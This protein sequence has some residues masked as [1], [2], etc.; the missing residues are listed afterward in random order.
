MMK[1][2]SSNSKD[3]SY[4]HVLMCLI[5]RSLFDDYDHQPKFL[6]CHHTFC[7]DC[8]RE[9][10]RQIGD[11]IECPSCRKIANIPAAGVAALQTNFY[12][13]Y[14]QSLVSGGSGQSSYPLECAKH[15]SEKLQFF[16]ENCEVSMC[17]E[18]NTDSSATCD[19]EKK[20][21][22]TR[23]TEESH[24]K[25]DTSFSEANATIEERKVK[26]E[27]ALKALA[28]EKDSALLKID[29]TFEQ[30]V[31]TLNRRATLLKNKVIDIYN[32]HVERLE[33]DLMEISTA[34]TCIVSLKDYHEDKIS[35]GDYR[36]FSKGIE[37]IEEVNKNIGDRIHP[38]ETHII[39]EG[40]HGSEKFRA[41]AK[42]IGR[43]K[44][45]RVIQ[46]PRTEPEGNDAVDSGA[47]IA[48][49]TAASGAAPN[50]PLTPD[51]PTT[52]TLS[53]GLHDE[54]LTPAG[55]PDSPCDTTLNCPEGSG[56]CGHHGPGMADLNVNNNSNN[57]TDTVTTSTDNT[58]LENQAFAETQPKPQNC[59]VKKKPNL[60]NNNDPNTGNPPTEPTT[61]VSLLPSPD[62]SK[63]Q[64]V[65]NPG[66]GG[67]KEKN[68]H[69]QPVSKPPAPE[70]VRVVPGASSKKQA[71]SGIATIASSGGRGRP[72]YLTAIPGVKSPPAQP[73]SKSPLLAP[74]S[75]KSLKGQVQRSPQGGSGT[76]P[77]PSRLP[78]AP[79]SCRIPKPRLGK[80]GQAEY[81]K[82]QGV[83]GLT[84]RSPQGQR[85]PPSGGKTNLPPQGSGANNG[86]P[87][88]NRSMAARNANGNVPMQTIPEG[89][90][91]VNDPEKAKAEK[92]YY[93]LLYTSYDEEELLKELKS[94]KANLDDSDSWMTISSG[95]ESNS[96]NCSDEVLVEAEQTSF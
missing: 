40:S 7:K 91:N 50:P 54:A 51:S 27:K 77:R 86:N 95:D 38:V 11:E 18:C 41:A 9:Y 56:N 26:I 92:A 24:Q 74:G 43:V 75:D 6:P 31:H 8:L 58:P 82:G 67:D 14:I 46:T 69:S 80:P 15:P 88:T 78:G 47:P 1:R 60:T 28:E 2:G 36:E 70:D 32:E 34:L 3:E 71:S 17:K 33:N 94:G 62:S 52:P 37:D 29:S 72:R 10:C 65:M 4:E 87:A 64:T 83:S 89:E 5:C 30:H 63:A 25:L 35:H 93:H 79:G 20:V 42:D 22:I 85:L 12:V 49:A 23:I 19:H 55:T 48:G 96:T 73:P 81:R 53:E 16:C 90:V 68:E 61:E 59:D 39:F 21:A 57:V 66:D 13:K 76:I 84:R 44:F 45:T